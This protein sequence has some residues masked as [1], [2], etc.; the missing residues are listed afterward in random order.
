MKLKEIT[1]MNTLIQRFQ[2]LHNDET[3]QG[4]VEYIMLIALVI[5]AAVACFPGLSDA[6][7]AAFLAIGTKLGKYVN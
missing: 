7:S 1:P 5:T 4:L 2:Q 3:G 6:L